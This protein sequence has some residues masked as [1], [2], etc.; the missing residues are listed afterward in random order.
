M[1]QP[2]SIRKLRRRVFLA[3]VG[4]AVA[5]LPVLAPAVAAAPNRC[6]AKNLTQGTPP[7][8]HL[9]GVIDTARAG[10]RIK[11]KQ[12]CVGHFRIGKQLALIGEGTSGVPVPVLRTNGAGRVLLV[13][14]RV[15]LTNLKITGG[16]V[17]RGGGIW[18]AS[19]TLILNRSTV[20]GNQAA[21]FG[22]GIVNDR[23]TVVLNGSSRIRLNS[24][25]DYGGGIFNFGG[26]VVLNG[27]SSVGQNASDLGGG[28]YNDDGGA[29]TMNGSA[30]I[31]GN[32]AGEGGGIYNDDAIVRLKNGSSVTGNTATTGGGIRFGG[33]RACD[34]SSADEW[35]G[36]I[37]PNDPDDPPTVSPIACT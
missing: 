6:W 18:N 13:K 32:T 29:I 12:V 36:A 8:S 37:S 34:G 15:T 2:R 19:G 22:G 16:S 3:M 28:I 21:I 33:V 27:S 10:D 31:S 30:A 1:D 14:A 4:L 5:M 24:A 9:Q 17:E 26:T 20:S 11:V 7:R 25:T 35:T 23:G